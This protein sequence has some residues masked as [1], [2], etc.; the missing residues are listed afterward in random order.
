MIV[1]A[2]A[3]LL[4]LAWVPIN[5]HCLLESVPGL[6]FV[7]CCADAEAPSPAPVGDPCKDDGCCTVESSHYQ[8]PRE[9]TAA[10]LLLLAILVEVCPVIPEGVTLS[11]V[12]TGDPP[13]FPPPELPSSWQF[14]LRTALPVRA[15]SLAS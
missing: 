9:E 6:E 8:V 12:A 2:V 3:L 4:A 13:A 1:R 14:A 7:R 11:E 5:A 10:S 15:P